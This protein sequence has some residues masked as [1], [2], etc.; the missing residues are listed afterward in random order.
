[1][2]TDI[3]II[4]GF[5]GAGKTTL[6]RKLLKETFHGERVV[7]VE[8]DFGEAGVDASLLRADGAAVEEIRAGCI[9]CSLSG[10]LIKS[11]KKLIARYKPDK[12]LIE[13]SGVGKLSDV[14]AACGAEELRDRAEIRRAI[15]VVDAAR[16]A[17]Y[18]EN[19]GEFFTDQIEHADA[20]LLSRAADSADGADA[21]RAL[22]RAYNADAELFCAPW[23][24]LRAEDLLSLR[25][26][27]AADEVSR[28]GSGEEHCRDEHCHDAHCHDAHC[29][30]AHCHGAHGLSA[31]D[32]FDSV[33]IRTERVFSKA[34]LR[35]R[36]SRM[37]RGAAGTVLRAKGIL[38]G[39]EGY[40]NLQYLPGDTRIEVCAAGGDDMLSVIGRDLNGPDLA[41]LFG[42]VV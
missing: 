15:T 25:H 35:A 36:V 26:A 28:E 37:E 3:Y 12:I 9:C 4:S 7:V 13:P 39:T 8:N 17:V 19:F 41:A 1:M 16:C 32:A 31:E 38:R 10:D 21:A 40:L 29:H 30:D 27:R 23:E 14:A 5:L 24:D 2:L 11:L 34:D 18:A 33:T 20:V 6:I 22:V 42:G